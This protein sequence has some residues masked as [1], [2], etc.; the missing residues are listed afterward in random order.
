[1]NGSLYDDGRIRCDEAGIRIGWY[2][3]WGAKRIPYAS[4]RDF[5]ILPL[6][7][8]NKARKW[9]LWGSGDF[10][11]WWNLDAGR[12]HKNIALVLDVGRRTQ[13]T[14][15]PDDPEAVERILRDHA[16]T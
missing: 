14:N 3:P 4:V 1:M 13:P 8:A 6:T 9:R 16:N 2:Y 10:V 12:P 7:G 11:H 15:T 5:E